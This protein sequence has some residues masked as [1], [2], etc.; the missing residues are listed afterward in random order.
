M[1]LSIPYKPL[2]RCNLE[3]LAAQQAMNL[4]TGRAYGGSAFARKGECVEKDKARQAVFDLIGPQHYSFLTMPGI[5]WLFESQLIK[6]RCPEWR[7]L[8]QGFGYHLTCVENDRF[9]YYSATT[10]MPGNKTSTI[11]TL[12]RPLYAERDQANGFIQRYTFCNVDDMLQTDEAYNFVWL[13]Y[14]GPLSVERMRVIKAFFESSTQLDVLVITSLKARWNRAT[15]DT[16]TRN[17]GIGFQVENA[18]AAVAAAWALG[19]DWPTIHA[20]L[21]PQVDGDGAFV[22][23]DVSGPSPLDHRDGERRTAGELV[24]RAARQVRH[25]RDAGDD[26]ADEEPCSTAAA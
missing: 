12:P 1:I 11:H 19:F 18:M 8:E 22:R 20:G 6:S 2:S 26:E 4:R 5:N 16:I 17:G 3:E 25:H 7:A 14:T 15:S 24:R 13:D 21:N 10:K 23:H 9:I